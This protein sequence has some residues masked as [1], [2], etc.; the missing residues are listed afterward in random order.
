MLLYSLI[1]SSEIG[2]MIPPRLPIDQR[3]VKDTGISR[4]WNFC[5]NFGLVARV[6]P[7]QV[8]PKD[9]SKS[10]TL[11]SST[12]VEG[13]FQLRTRFVM[14]LSILVLVKLTDCRQAYEKALSQSLYSHIRSGKIEDAMEI[15]HAVDQPWRSALLR[16]AAQ[17]RWDGLCE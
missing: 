7:C 9:S 12:G 11:T 15:C 2:Y 3:P 16:G 13:C 14:S 6:A 10:W 17:F 5:I 4:N 8:A 1:S